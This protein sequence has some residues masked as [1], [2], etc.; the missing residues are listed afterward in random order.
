MSKKEKIFFKYQKYCY[1]QLDK[2][3]DDGWDDKKYKL[4]MPP[5]FILSLLFIPALLSHKNLCNDGKQDLLKSFKKIVADYP[6]NLDDFFEKQ[7]T[8]KRA[9]NVVKNSILN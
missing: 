8:S 9:L 2:I 7:K 5:E 3:L 6:E 4:E 1:E